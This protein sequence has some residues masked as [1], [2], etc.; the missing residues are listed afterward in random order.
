MPLST[1]LHQAPNTTAILVSYGSNGY[2]VYSEQLSNFI[3]Y[4][5]PKFGLKAYITMEGFNKTEVLVVSGVLKKI[6]LLVTF[7]T[8]S[9]FVVKS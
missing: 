2:G 6:Q 3:S 9:M 1:S 8:L 5:N 4:L 7:V